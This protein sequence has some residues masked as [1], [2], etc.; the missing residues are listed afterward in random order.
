MK[1][2][3]KSLLRVNQKLIPMNL[4]YFMYAFGE[5]QHYYGEVTFFTYFERVQKIYHFKLL[6]Y[7]LKMKMHQKWKRSL[8]VNRNLIPMNLV[9]FMYAFGEFKCPDVEVAFFSNNERAEKNIISNY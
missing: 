1:P 6:N 4:V 5:F 3:W 9:Y 2:E 7:F 8:Q